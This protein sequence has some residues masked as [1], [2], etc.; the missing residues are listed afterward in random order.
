MATLFAADVIAAGEHFLQHIAVTNLG[1][2]RGDLVC[3]GKMEE[4]QI[5]HH[6]H[7]GSILFQL[8]LLLQCMST[9]GND[10]IAVHQFAVL[11]HCQT[12]VCITVK[13]QTQITLVGLYIFHQVFHVSGAAVLIDIGAVR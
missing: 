4:A 10:L 2:L 13:C 1:R 3:L 5:C 6:S 8:A 9:N 12:T 7:N 11:V